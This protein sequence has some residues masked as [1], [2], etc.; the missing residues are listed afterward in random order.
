MPLQRQLS[1]AKIDQPAVEALQSPT[2]LADHFSSLSVSPQRNEGAPRRSARV[3]A[4]RSSSASVSRSNSLRPTPSKRRRLNRP[5]TDVKST[6]KAARD[7]KRSKRSTGRRPLRK[8]D[9]LPVP[10][11][12]HDLPG[13]EQECDLLYEKLSDALKTQQGCCICTVCDV[14]CILLVPLTSPFPPPN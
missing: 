6:R 1:T 8:S 9:P 13:R 11:K 10:R 2:R 3:A 5:A 7:K 12:T 14:M 4:S